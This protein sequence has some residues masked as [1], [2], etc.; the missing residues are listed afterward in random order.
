MNLDDLQSS[1]GIKFNDPS[2]L[3]K[4][5]VH[6]S[7]LNETSDSDIKESNERLEFLGDAILQFLSSEFLY[8]TYP[9]YVEGDLT[10]IRSKIVNTEALASESRNL[11][12]GAHLL[13]SRGEK[14]TAFASS[15]ILANTFEAMLGSIYLDQGIE[16]CRKFLG[17]H[18]FYKVEDVVKNG[19]FKDA[20]SLYQEIAQEKYCITPTYKVLKD[21]GPDHNKTFTIGV[22][23]DEK[24]IAS[25]SGT[26]KRRAEQAAADAALQLESQKST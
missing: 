10:N 16:A 23:L 1:L 14:E 24:L 4:A 2:Q 13:I 25:G 17:E 20:K 22:Y 3:K 7:Y 11:N 5:L 19:T 9:D 21:E 12:V 15:S 26:S 18:L 8:K 6:R